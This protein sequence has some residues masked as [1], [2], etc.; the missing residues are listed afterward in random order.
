MTDTNAKESDGESGEEESITNSLSNGTRM[1][2]PRRLTVA[3][4]PLAVA[5]M[6]MGDMLSFQA[7]PPT[8]IML[9]RVA[10]PQYVTVM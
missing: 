7:P 3:Y 9:D 4:I 8:Q 5:L 6:M 2:Y 10:F 1:C